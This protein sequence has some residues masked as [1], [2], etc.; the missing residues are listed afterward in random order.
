M[1]VSD[2]GFDDL[3]REHFGPVCRTAFLIVGDPEEARD[4]AQEAFVR[5]FQH[6]RKVSRYDRPEAWVHR[7]AAN[8]AISSVRRAR[9]AARVRADVHDPEIPDAELMD[10]L[11][12]LTPAQRAVVALRFY[13]DWTVEDVAQALGKRPGTIRALTHQGIERLRSQLK[14]EQPDG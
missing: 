12:I 2:D 10:A 5:A 4:V 14:E 1:D 7:V 11:A 3:W 13:L 6:W 9:R 8:L